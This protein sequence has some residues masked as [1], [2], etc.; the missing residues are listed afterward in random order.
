MFLRFYSRL[1]V[2]TVSLMAMVP[3]DAINLGTD[4]AL[5][6][7]ESDSSSHQMAQLTAF[8]DQINSTYDSISQG[9]SLAQT[10]A[11]AGKFLSAK[12]KTYLK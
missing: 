6:R 7:P 1:A 8:G 10:S 12:G 2:A 11:E 5:P 4:K 3:T 9:H